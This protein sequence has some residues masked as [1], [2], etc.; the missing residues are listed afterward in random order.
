[1]TN[2]ENIRRRAVIHK[3]GEIKALNRNIATMLKSMSY[4][5]DDIAV[6]TVGVEEMVINALIHGNKEDSKKS[7]KVDASIS[8]KEARITIEDEGEGFDLDSVA[9]PTDFTR[10]MS[11]I[12]DGAVEEF[13]HGRGIWMTREYMDSVV[14]NKKGNKVTIVKLKEE[15]ETGREEVEVSPQSIKWEKSLTS[16]YLLQGEGDIDIDFHEKSI[17]SSQE[18]STI[19][20]V[21]KESVKQKRKII[22]RTP[23]INLKES[24]KAMNIDR[25][26]M[27]KIIP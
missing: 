2:M 9:D 23:S 24:L 12:E 25:F 13:T 6:I 26:D 11:L 21:I 27:V 16:G 4:T 14:Y 15:E 20:F 5:K 17:I 18:L 19:L 1:M 10:L 7:V 22:L 8:S 3:R